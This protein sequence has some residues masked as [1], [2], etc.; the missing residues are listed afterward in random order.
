M[1]LFESKQRV[2]F[3]GAGVESS[4]VVDIKR[5]KAMTLKNV[6]DD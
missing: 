2:E 6:H 4:L 5:K 1:T 3:K